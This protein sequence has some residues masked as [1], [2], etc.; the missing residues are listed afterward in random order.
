MFTAQ[1]IDSFPIFEA[2]VDNLVE[3]YTRLESPT[4]RYIGKIQSASYKYLTVFHIV[5]AP[6][7]EDRFPNRSPKLVIVTDTFIIRILETEQQQGEE[8]ASR[9]N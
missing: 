9:D 5:P 2:E 4:K 3:F 1:A 6:G 7:F 8:H